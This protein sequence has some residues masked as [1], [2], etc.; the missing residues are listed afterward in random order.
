[1]APAGL[2]LLAATTRSATQMLCAT[3]L[4]LALL[5]GGVIEVIRFHYAC[6]LTIDFVGDGRM[7]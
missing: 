2:T 6:Q 5:A 7:A 4:G 1:M 3:L